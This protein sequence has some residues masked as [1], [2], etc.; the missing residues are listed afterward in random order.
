MPDAASGNSAA[1]SLERYAASDIDPGKPGVSVD[2]PVPISQV[3]HGDI[4]AGGGVEVVSP[5]GSQVCSIHSARGAF[6]WPLLSPTGAAVT[7][8][9]AT[10]ADHAL[11]RVL[12]P[13]DGTA[14]GAAV[15]GVVADDDSVAGPESVGVFG[16]TG[17]AVFPPDSRRQT[18][19]GY[20][21]H[22]VEVSRIMRAAFEST[23]TSNTSF[24]GIAPRR[25]AGPSEGNSITAIAGSNR[26][27]GFHDSRWH[28]AEQQPGRCPVVLGPPRQAGSSGQAEAAE[29]VRCTKQF[30]GRP[31][32]EFA[33]TCEE[34][35]DQAPAWQQEEDSG[36]CRTS[37][38]DSSR[39]QFG[40]AR[41]GSD[42]STN[43]AVKSS[44]GVLRR[45]SR[46]PPREYVVKQLTPKQAR[47]LGHLPWMQQ[48]EAQLTGSQ[49]PALLL[50]PFSQ[51]EDIASLFHNSSCSSISAS[52]D[53]CDIR[54][55]L[56]QQLLAKPPERS[57]SAYTS[58]DR[59]ERFA[60]VIIRTGEEVRRESQRACSA[61]DSSL[62]FATRHAS[63]HGSASTSPAVQAVRPACSSRAGTNVAPTTAP[64]NSGTSATAL[65]PMVPWQP[66]PC[67]P[68]PV[69]SPPHFVDLSSGGA[70]AP[71]T[72]AA[73]MAGTGIF[74]DVHAPGGRTSQRA[75][76]RQQMPSACPSP[77]KLPLSPRGL[78][79]P[80]ATAAHAGVLGCS[81]TTA[82]APSQQFTPRTQH[83]P[84]HCSPFCSPR[85][86]LT[87][88]TPRRSIVGA[89]P[90]QVPPQ[91][92][93]G[94]TPKK[95]QSFAP[96]VS[97]RCAVAPP[98]W[99]LG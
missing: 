87:S 74:I 1:L 7:K 8:G 92:T 52:S 4:A 22:S 93:T 2:S 32:Q 37:A 70:A 97:S 39:Q 49:S 99:S 30:E 12:E 58:T 24:E 67:N 5:G 76:A 61:T 56:S 26:E 11:D 19:D 59:S 21:R 33:S 18:P 53:E 41:P 15:G 82:A 85:L 88:N 80:H 28:V 13:C 98:R 94:Q 9:T 55:R 40:C 86:S 14:A 84:V 65:S 47:E 69:V 10:V 91:R 60:D 3:G 16:G 62:G 72:P 75:Q 44:A 79:H 29:S 50:C 89:S 48:C 31:N 83:P 66:Q 90:G 95:R 57:Q 96:A 73:P 78:G 77:A 43:G 6:Q 81:M 46:G 54:G 63:Y 68:Q 23:T 25:A 38:P 35:A 34:R 17:S 42:G 51:G 45:A 71:P 27:D 20:E 36:R 64:A